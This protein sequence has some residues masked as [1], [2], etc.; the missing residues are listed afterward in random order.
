VL[1]PP[2]LVAL[3]VDPSSLLSIREAFPQCRIQIV[4]GATASTIV[5]T[6]NPRAADLVV[7]GMV[8]DGGTSLEL[9]RSLGSCKRCSED[10]N[11]RK[12]EVVEAEDGQSTSR[13]SNAPLLV[14]LSP[15]Q[16]HLVQAFLEAGAHSCL[17][18]PV[19][20]KD[21]FGMLKHA[22]AGNQPGRHTLHVEG[23]QREDV[24]RDAGGEG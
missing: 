8:G 13:I 19:H 17:V 7:L 2:Q 11:T 18:R 24:W 16:G 14:L 4:N 23:A 12:P 20:F 5:S 10:F 9:C 6:W 21:V 15:G 3:D 1:Q 22:Q